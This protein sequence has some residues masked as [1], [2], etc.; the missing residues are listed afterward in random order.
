VFAVDVEPDG[1][2]AGPDDSW[3]GTAVTLRE[4]SALRHRLHDG[5]KAPVVLNWFPRFDP[6][7]QRAFGRRDWVVE[8]CPNL[9][10]TAAANADFIGIHIHLWRWHAA[11]GVWFSDF[12][13]AAWRAECLGSSVEG[14]REVFG[15]PP[16]ATRFGDRMLQHDDVALLRQSGIRYDLTVEPGVPS[17]RLSIDRL[18]SRH[19]PDYRGAP[20][21]PYR[22]SASNYLVPRATGESVE[23]LWLVPVTVTGRSYWIPLRHSPFLIR[24]TLPLNLVLR[25]GRA[26]AELSAEMDREAPEPIVSVLRSGDL[27]NPGLLANFRFITQRMANHPRIGHCRFVGVDRA[28]EAFAAS[29]NTVTVLRNQGAPPLRSRFGE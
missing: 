8:A 19:L 5:T 2:K 16:I 24:T 4:L 17:H 10:P 7:I 22:P 6:H 21:R 29:Q 18:A 15:A 11:R 23:D 27:S 1:R 12:A 3:E 26:W 9:F 25:P 14:Y 20:R 13:D 28:V